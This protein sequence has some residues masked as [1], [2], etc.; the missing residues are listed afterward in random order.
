MNHPKKQ[1]AAKDRHLSTTQQGKK[2]EVPFILIMVILQVSVIALNLI[3]LRQA[4]VV[5]LQCFAV[6][7]LLVRQQLVTEIL[8]PMVVEVAL[9]GNL[10][11]LALTTTSG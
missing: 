5:R 1:S 4:L 2:T 8:R 3:L 10:K 7:S 6:K 11:Q 9:C